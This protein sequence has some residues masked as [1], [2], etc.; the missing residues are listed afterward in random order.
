MERCPDKGVEIVGQAV[1]GQAVVAHS[2]RGL[3]FPRLEFEDA[4]QGVIAVAEPQLG[5]S[6]IRP[7]GPDAL[8]GALV[9]PVDDEAAVGDGMIGQLVCL[10]LMKRVRIAPMTLVLAR[11]RGRCLVG[12]GASPSLYGGR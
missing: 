11:R 2:G 10:C 12:R 8:G 6:R 5:R 7:R 3:A 4:W 9:D 1:V